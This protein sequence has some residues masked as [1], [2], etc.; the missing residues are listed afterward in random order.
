MID[1]VE[2]TEEGSKEEERCFVFGFMCQKDIVFFFFFYIQV[3][4]RW[5]QEILSNF[6]EGRGQCTVQLYGIRGCREQI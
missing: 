1:I 5:V 4:S 6:L 3:L 2:N